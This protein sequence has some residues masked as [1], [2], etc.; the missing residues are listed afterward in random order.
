MFRVNGPTIAGYEHDVGTRVDV[1]VAWAWGVDDARSRNLI[2]ARET[3]IIVTTALN[4]DAAPPDTWMNRQLHQVLA[5]NNGWSSALTR[6]ILWAG[7]WPST[8]FQALAIAMALAQHVGAPPPRVYG[9]GACQ[10]C[11]KYYDCDGS[12]STRDRDGLADEAGGTNG[13]YHAFR[14]EHAARVAWHAAGA[15]LLREPSCEGFPNYPDSPPPPAPPVPPA[16][17]PRP[18]PAPHTPPKPCRPPPMAPPRLPPPPPAL[19]PAPLPAVPPSTP[20]PPVRPSPPPSPSPNVP[21]APPLLPPSPPPASVAATVFSLL[22]HT[23]DSTVRHSTPTTMALLCA[24][25]SLSGVALGVALSF[26]CS[27]MLLPCARAAG[28]C[29]RLCCCCATVCLNASRGSR[30]R[31]VHTTESEADL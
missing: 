3:T 13:A 10:P 29:A 26:L 2:D 24:P 5:V 20:P 23:C 21:P 11:A 4:Q 22:T 6:D 28:R 8:G 17:P 19:P 1:R 7:Q 9:F 30:R 12:N 25:P 14:A 27:R 31:L 16:A 15:I 18:P